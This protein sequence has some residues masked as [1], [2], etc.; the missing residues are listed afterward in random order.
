MEPEKQSNNHHLPDGLFKL[1]YADCPWEYRSKKSGGSMKSGAAQKYPTMTL[2][3]ICNLPV[4]KIADKKGC[5]LFLWVTTPLK[6]DI[7]TS[8]LLESWSFEY[9]TTVYWRKIMSMGMGYW[10]RGQVEECWL[11]TRGDVKAFRFQIPNF[12]QTKA[13]EHSQK[14]RAFRGLITQIASQF[15]LLPAIELFSR[16]RIEGWTMFGN[17]LPSSEQ[18]LL[19]T[20]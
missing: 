6:Y 11:C 19:N 17:D 5:V 16:D 4:S 18:K 10:F 14:P 13:T 2:T 9:K 1:I 7:A 20:E 3:E 8:G 12:I 15:N